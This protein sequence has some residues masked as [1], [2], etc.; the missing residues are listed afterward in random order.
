MLL[1]CAASHQ[2]I[3]LAL[4]NWSNTPQ[5]GSKLTPTQLMY[6]RKTKS[7]LISTPNQLNKTPNLNKFEEII[8]ER[9]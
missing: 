6:G 5:E 4:L 1:K 9:K 8:T 3:N 7:L 2:D